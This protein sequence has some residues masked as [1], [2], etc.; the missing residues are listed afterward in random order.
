MEHRQK[1]LIMCVTPLQILIAE[2][3]IQSKP[4]EDFDV[5]IFALESNE[6]FSYYAEKLKNMLIHIGIHM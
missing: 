3:I 6:K 1:S 4:A 5:I 2:K